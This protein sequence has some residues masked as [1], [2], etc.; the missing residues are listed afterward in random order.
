MSGDSERREKLVTV[1]YGW[2]QSQDTVCAGTI[3]LRKDIVGPQRYSQTAALSA[4]LEILERRF[5]G[6]SFEPW[7]GRHTLRVFQPDQMSM[8]L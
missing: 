7:N 1:R 8:Q 5:P 6:W 4:L 2:H 3:G